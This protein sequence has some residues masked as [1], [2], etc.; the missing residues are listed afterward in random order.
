MLRKRLLNTPE[1]ERKHIRC[2]NVRCYYNIYREEGYILCDAGFV[3]GV[4]NTMESSFLDLRTK[5]VHILSVVGC[6]RHAIETPYYIDIPW[7]E[8]D[9][10][11]KEFCIQNI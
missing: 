2:N 5:A 1:K 9:K 3:V 10:H 8:I 11:K 6:P 4:G 7:T